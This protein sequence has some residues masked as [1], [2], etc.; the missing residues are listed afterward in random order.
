M[1]NMN[2]HI[3]EKILLLSVWYYYSILKQKRSYNEFK[4]NGNQMRWR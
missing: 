1:K 3:R 4:Q 2:L